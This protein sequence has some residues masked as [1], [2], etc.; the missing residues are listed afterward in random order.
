M[1]RAYTWFSLAATAG[2]QSAAK[3][4]DVAVERKTVDE[5]AETTRR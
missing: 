5:I 4:L 1:I 2:N 3:N